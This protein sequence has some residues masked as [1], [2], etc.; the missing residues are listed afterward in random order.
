MNA[1]NTQAFWKA[2]DKYTFLDVIMIACLAV[3]CFIAGIFA[4]GKVSG[5]I[6]AIVVALIAVNVPRYFIHL[7]MTRSEKEFSD[8]E[9]H[10]LYENKPQATPALSRIELLLQTYDSLVK[11]TT[12]LMAALVVNFIL[13]VIGVFS[14]ELSSAVSVILTGLMATCG[15]ADLYQAYTKR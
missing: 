8:Y 1:S 15:L 3:F 5:A 12:A 13:T 7:W 9:G 10:T 2:N 6:S 11:K 4:I 14:A